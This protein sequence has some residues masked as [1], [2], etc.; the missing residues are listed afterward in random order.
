MSRVGAARWAGELR[1]YQEEALAAL[2][3]RWASGDKRAWVVLPPGAGKTLVG[4]E[5]ARRLGR[6]TVV[7]TP[8]TAIQ[9]QWITQWRA[10]ERPD[11]CTAGLRRSLE[12]DVTVLTYQ[13]LAVFD[14][15]AE[16]DEEGNELSLLGRLHGNGGALV[17]ALHA[18]GPIT[19]ILDECHHLLQMW[20]RLLAEVLADLE[21]AHVIGLTG[22]PA[23]SL[24]ANEAGLVATLFGAPVHGASIPAL[25]RDGYL[26]PFAELVWV[27]EPT[28][29]ERDYITEQG[30]RFT[31]LC[32][33]LLSPG[34]ARTD[35]PTWLRLR[36]DE[37][38]TET[39]ERLDWARLAAQEPELT[40]AVLRLHHAG[41]SPLPEGARVLER[42]RGTPTADDWMALLSDYVL[43][44]LRG[45]PGGGRPD[46]AAP[47]AGDADDRA[48]E[49]IRTALPAIGYTLTRYGIRSGRS[50]VDRVLARSA[51]KS[52]GTVE[53]AAA[54]AAS[55][56]PRLRALVLCDHE[57]ASARPSARLLEVLG[58]Q[59][60]S[61]WLQLE[62]L[63][64]DER[65]RA[66]SPMLVTGRT[67]AAAPETAEAF[68]AF[69]TER[70]PGLELSVVE[71]GG[72]GSLVRVEGRWTSRSWVRMVTDYVERG[73][74]RV[75]VGTR[76]LLG[77]GW[78]ARTVNTVIDLTTATTPTSVVQG[79]GRALR[80]DP[81]WPEKTAHTWTVVCVSDAH[82]KG[83]ADWERFVRK[84]E[85]Y[86]GV[87]ADGEV[88]S[89]VAHVDPALSPYGP[90]PTAEL[91]AVNARMLA[92]AEDREDTRER[93]RIGSPY[94][95][96]LLSTL[97]VRPQRHGSLAPRP[98][99]TRPP[100][101]LAVPAAAGISASAPPTLEPTRASLVTG[102][103]VLLVSVP[104]MMLA[105]GLS[106]GV[107]GVIAMFLA[108]GAERLAARGP[109]FRFAGHL[110][111]AA[112]GEPD[113]VRFGY[114]VADALQG[115]G[116]SP[117]GAEGV[118]LDIDTDGTFR[119]T[120]T[121]AGPAASEAFSTALDE[122]VSPLVGTPRYIVARYRLA[123]P[124]GHTHARRLGVA[125]MRGRAPDNPVVFHAV[126]ALL[127]RNRRGA[128]A[129]STAWNRWISS[130]EPVYTASPAGSRLLYA[131]YATDPYPVQ[132][133]SRLTWS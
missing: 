58:A 124:A 73:D 87:A 121:G 96:E 53:I 88:M 17:E 4:L 43:K 71:V 30:L 33:D 90:P 24:S 93:W 63:V 59:A 6:R 11:G 120:F 118:R 89:G 130:G 132:T 27:T 7:F 23:E 72:D 97:R 25:V 91:D 21:D 76:A 98:E 111:E 9:G 42:H 105:L 106:S 47:T 37:R 61:A 26:A 12:H 78:D 104:A 128:E 55:L 112:G 66:L 13:S 129:F 83:G 92:R 52:Q 127:A 85:G 15:D 8:N 49:R 107:S 74:C 70:R 95:D 109:R 57:R 65:T 60:G 1:P 28:P 22:T 2:D 36:F 94:V 50:P 102:A 115:A 80:L 108:L 126:P 103:A 31:E 45:K 14:P 3:A 117:V 40:D 68:I 77:E 123:R 100:A 54:E 38:T 133:A 39:G 113:I 99:G 101:P 51:A 19:V 67:V 44:C 86:L 79:R 16:T 131:H 35:F 75:L 20:G 32:T 122:V 62:L 119:L 56:G 48:L 114:A 46:V 29:A 81:A 110:M 116:Y 125:W 34:F 10:F 82:P 64:A 18:A 84:H 69:A 5:A 41:L